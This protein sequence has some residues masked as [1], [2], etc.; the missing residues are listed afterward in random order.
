MA[1]LQLSGMT[2]GRVEVSLHPAEISSDMHGAHYATVSV[3][4]KL[5]GARATLTRRHVGPNRDD[6]GDPKWYA[7]VAR[8][9]LKPANADMRHALHKKRTDADLVNVNSPEASARGW[10]AQF[11]LSDSPAFL[12]PYREWSKRTCSCAVPKLCPNP[13]C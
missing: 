9:K 11:Q 1:E 3:G 13:I 12:L 5:L 7:G 4:R 8:N 6:V 2:S 10:S